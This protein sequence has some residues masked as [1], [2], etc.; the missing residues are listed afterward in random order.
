MA[1]RRWDCCLHAV[2]DTGRCLMEA[3]RSGE[4][5]A[6]FEQAPRILDR[7]SWGPAISK[8]PWFCASWVTCVYLVGRPGDD[9]ELIE[10]VLKIKGPKDSLEWVTDGQLS[11]CSEVTLLRKERNS[12]RRTAIKAHLLYFFVSGL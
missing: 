4:A 1:A 6:V 2:D 3:G 10:R 5:E 8:L 9:V 12:D 11:L 7:P